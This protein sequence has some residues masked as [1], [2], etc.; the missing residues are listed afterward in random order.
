MTITRHNWPPNPRHC[1][2]CGGCFTVSF[3]PRTLLYA[4]SLRLLSS[5]QKAPHPHSR[6]ELLTGQAPGTPRQISKGEVSGCHPPSAAHPA[7]AGRQKLGGTPGGGPR[8][9]GWVPPSVAGSLSPCGGCCGLGDARTLHDGLDLLGRLHV[10]RHRPLQQ[11]RVHLH[12]GCVH[13]HHEPARPPVPQTHLRA[14]ITS[15]GQSEP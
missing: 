15:P 10:R 11:L 2:S 9:A 14:K 1:R 6:I 8:S 13:A 12:H 7:Q 3:I 4:P 5:G